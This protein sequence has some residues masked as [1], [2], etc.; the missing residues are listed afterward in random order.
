MTTTTKRNQKK[1]SNKHSDK[2]ENKGSFK[3]RYIDVSG[4]KE[5]HKLLMFI[6]WIAI[7]RDEK[8]VKTHTEFARRFGVSKDTLTDWKKLPHF[9]KEVDL[10]R[11][12]FFH[13][14]VSE[15][16]YGQVKSA[17]KGNPQSAKLLL[18]KYEGFREGTRVEE[19]SPELSEEAMK[20]IDTAAGNWLGLF[21][22]IREEN[23]RLKQG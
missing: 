2:S 16:M 14:K 11:D 20:M 23:R 10:Y 7:P 13:S 17:I 8:G 19:V 3:F 9:W 18:Q 22:R 21:N 6:Q 1:I 5:L 12:P 4:I 15:Y